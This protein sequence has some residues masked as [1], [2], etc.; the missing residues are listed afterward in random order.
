MISVR[1]R[2]AE[3]KLQI[4]FIYVFIYK[5]LISSIFSVSILVFGLL[6]A[7]CKMFNRL[8]L[9]EMKMLPFMTLQM[10]GIRP[11]YIKM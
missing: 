2:S 5:K 11:L 1:L 7:G 3:R 4:L 8:K 9:K 6:I 10:K